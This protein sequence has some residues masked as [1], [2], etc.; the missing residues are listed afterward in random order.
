MFPKSKSNSQSRNPEPDLT[1]I[2]SVV[3]ETRLADRMNAVT[4]SL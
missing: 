1:E 4:G 2:C 3:S